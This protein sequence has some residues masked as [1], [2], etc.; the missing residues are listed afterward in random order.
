M[1]LCPIFASDALGTEKKSHP[2]GHKN[3][4]SLNYVINS[5]QASAP[6]TKL[7]FFVALLLL[8]I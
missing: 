5:H 3:I 6:E 1:Y 8:K 2:G 4:K 7:H